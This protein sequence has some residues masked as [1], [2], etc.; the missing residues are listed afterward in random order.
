[1]PIIKKI[2]IVFL[3]IFLVF[4]SSQSKSEIKIAFIEMDTLINQS[5]AGK[6]LTEQLDKINK[7]NIKDFNEIEKK[8]LIKK[9][10]LSK[11]KNILSN[12]EYQKKV[13]E[14]NKKFNSTQAD[15]KSR[16][17]L[18]QS[19]KNEGIAKILKELNILLSEY[20]NK[21]QLTFIIDQKNVVIGKT[22]LN[23]TKEILKS[24]NQ[25][26]SKININ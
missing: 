13:I 19:K 9:N 18:L 22:E 14:L 16:I 4:L 24:L 26:I 11:K 25:K 10:D 3:F 21:N 17:K 7:K 2:K 23:I 1:M 12:D 15:V 5:L 8:L 20:S 6:S